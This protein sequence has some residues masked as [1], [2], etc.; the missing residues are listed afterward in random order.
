[1]RKYF[2]LFY[3]SGYVNLRYLNYNN[4]TRSGWVVPKDTGHEVPYGVLSRAL[5]NSVITHSVDKILRAQDTKKL[6]EDG[7]FSKCF[8]SYSSSAHFAYSQAYP[9]GM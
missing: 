4:W 8:I 6:Q 2:P 5:M 7:N 3:Q 9:K 1:M